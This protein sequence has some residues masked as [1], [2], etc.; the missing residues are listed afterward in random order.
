MKKIFTL[1]A[2]FLMTM[3]SVNAQYLLQ[4]DFEN[5]I[6][7]WTMVSM[8]STNN[9]FFGIFN[10]SDNA[11]EGD[12]C[13][14]FSSYLSAM[15]YNQ[16]LITPELT[17]NAEI[18]YMLQFY[19]RGYRASDK[20]KV[21]YSTTDNDISSFTV[22]Y[23]FE[24][25]PT[26]WTQASFA[27]PS[28]TKYVAI[29]YYGDFAYYL[30]VDNFN[31]GQITAPTVTINGPASVQTGASAQFIAESPLAETFAWTVDGTAVPSI[32]DTLSYTFSTV[33]IH[34]VSVTVSNTIG[35]ATATHTVEVYSCDEVQTLPY[36]EGFE[37]DLSACWQNIDND[38]DGYYWTPTFQYAAHTGNG[39]IYS[40]SYLNSVGALSPDNWLI[41]PAVDLSSNATL[42]FWVCAQD[43]RW[44]YE[45]YGVYISTTGT[46]TADF[47]L[48]FEETLDANSGAKTPSPW[49]QKT[50]S[51]YDYTGQTV[52]IAF[53]HFNCSDMFY[54]N[55][56]DI[57]ISN[58]PSIT[59]A[60]NTLSINTIV[61]GQSTATAT[62]NGLNLTDGITATTTAPFAVSSDGI[63]FNSTTTL[64]LTGGTLYVQY[65]ATAEGSETGTVTLSSTGAT[66]ETITL[67]GNAL[68][69]ATLPYSA[70]FEDSYEKTHWMI[71]GEGP[72][73]W[74][75]GTAANYTEDGGYAL[76]VSND[77]GTTNAYTN[78]TAS[79]SWA[80]RDIVF[81]QFNEYHLAFDFRGYGENNYDYLKVYLGYPAEVSASSF[82]APEGAT[83][84][85]T[86][87]GISDWTH[88]TTT[89]PS[90]FSGLQRL[91]LLWRNDGN[92]GTNP[93]A[94]IDNLTIVGSNCVAPNVYLSDF[95]PESLTLN[96]V[97]GN[98]ESSWEVEYCTD[99]ANWI[100]AGIVTSSPYTIDNLD[101]LTTY[102]IRIRSICGDG[103]FSDWETIQA[104]TSLCG[105]SERCAY[106]FNLTD[107]YG[108]G[109]NGCTLDVQ[110]NGV[111]VTTLGL[112]SGSSATETVNLCDNIPTSLVWHV[113]SYAYEA[114]FSIVS[115]YGEEIYSISNMADYTTQTFTTD[116]SQ[117]TCFRPTDIIISGISSTTMEV[118]WTPT[119]TETAWNLG[120]KEN[121]DDIWTV[122]PV[123]TNP[124]TLTNLTASTIYDV[125]V[126][127]DCGGGD[128]SS[129]SNAI[130][131]STTME[132]VGLPYTADFSDPNDAW[133]LKNGGCVN[134]WTMGMV[135]DED[136]LFVTT[137][138]T[139]PGYNITSTSVVS[140][141][142]L[143]TVGTSPTVTISYDVQVG[144][145]SHY[146]YLKMF[147]APASVEFPA[148][149]TAPASSD[150]AH[151][152]YSDYA[153][154][155]LSHNYST[156]ISYPYILNLLD[157]AIH[158][159]A[160][161][162]NPNANP[163]ANSTALL[164]FAWKNDGT[165]GTQP[166]AIIKNLT[167]TSAYTATDVA[168]I[169]A[170][171]LPYEWNGVIF[172][173]GGTQTATLQAENG[174]D[175]IVTMILTVNDVYA[176]TETR[177]VCPNE[178]PYEWNGVTFTAA[179][180]QIVT[181]TAANG[182]DS[183]GTM[184]L[185]I[186][187]T[188]TVTDARTICQSELPY[189]WNGVTFTAAGVQIATLQTVHG[190]DSVV[191]MALTVNDA[192]V[193]NETV[194]LCP[195]E[196]PYVWNDLT[197]TESGTQ[198]L[199]LQTENGCDSVLT[200]T[201]TVNSGYAVTETTFICPNELP[202]EWNG[203]TFTAAGIQNV[204]LTAADGCDSVVTM[205]LNIYPTFM[206]TDS[207]TICP[208]ELPYEWNGVTFTA[209]GV[210]ATSLQTINGC[211]SIVVMTLTVHDAI[212][213]EFTIETSDSCYHWNGQTYC[214][215]GDYT[216][217]FTAANGCDSVVTLHL[218]TSVGVVNHELG[219]SLY[220]APNPTKNISRIMGLSESLK[221]V[222]IMD[223][224]GRLVI[225]SYDHE[226]DVSTLPAGVYVVKVF[227][228]SGVTNL[229]LVKP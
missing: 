110:Q 18:T 170:S 6:D 54:L 52:R 120:Y 106:T 157:S 57:E 223:M 190:C 28:G 178:L 77:S 91:Y 72:N 42:S 215:S 65:S 85:G 113:G 88:F 22:L 171:E 155:F 100:S 71:V 63:N 162:A 227:T 70:D 133:V 213:S 60:P 56:D 129:W 32:T 181:L 68:E 23:D 61:G 225:K 159:Q 108:D 97:A 182:C 41:T 82:S 111:T 216:Q 151:S 156:N 142:K 112:S 121:S 197:F 55:I 164:V 67:I 40:A 152:D 50:I 94:A 36:F 226:I 64:P 10:S 161:M 137:D 200:M 78:S 35:S 210:Q 4:E 174:S 154:D 25:V 59:V 148:S 201:V 143:F 211:D 102:T 107:S 177:Y 184:M 229:K 109:W 90:S 123:T 222:E 13:F 166:A 1:L 51:L 2:V 206:V 79:V 38:G 39:M 186:N 160:T 188:Y 99:T 26:S 75:I 146:D 11:Y 195:S 7:N 212:T 217:T 118:S 53:R 179:G 189:E 31:I 62:V 16:Y 87:S 114:G 205:V 21:M 30:Y 27:L 219:T 19:Y 43:D 202:Y 209:A 138:S 105:A 80:Y 220:L 145:E 74:V 180:S 8:D 98:T 14:R 96:W 12:N 127:A 218:T 69:A 214:S 175:S 122:I 158:V 115:P 86:F 136:A 130:T 169:C 173:E 194:T 176:V 95:T 207:R 165:V 124:Y 203:V 163:D 48:L 34:T 5:D 119:G 37:N 103:E 126:Q 15:D 153:Y 191:V 104:T 168:T 46:D 141:Q 192:Y 117:P 167:V 131:A 204:T 29:N 45:H 139:S 92:V 93:P 83:L 132:P 193:A 101:T 221:C 183:V 128:I 187:P 73:N 89:L 24:T 58:V 140:A 224:R 144:G 149:S 134:Y 49:K 172:T 84:L 81:D 125:R 76:Y 44:G 198:T 135:D 33:G 228:E 3:L 150:Y 9:P 17:L 208:G 20:F 66:D 199:T 196:L 116:C 185:Y 147:L 47:T